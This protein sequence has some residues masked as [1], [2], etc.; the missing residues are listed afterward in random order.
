MFFVNIVRLLAV[1]RDREAFY[2]PALSHM[3][4]EVGDLKMCILV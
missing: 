4:R 1:L 2:Q 3:R